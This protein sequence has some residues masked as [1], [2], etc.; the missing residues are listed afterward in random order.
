MSALAA[1]A[2]SGKVATPMETV[3]GPPKRP[4]RGVFARIALRSFSATSA[5]CTRGQAGSST[6]ISSPP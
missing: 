4:E 6:A 3:S 1:R 2:S 5:A